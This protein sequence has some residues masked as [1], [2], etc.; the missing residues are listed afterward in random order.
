M[1]SKPPRLTQLINPFQVASGQYHFSK[2]IR[3]SKSKSKNSWQHMSLLLMMVKLK[4]RL[5]HTIQLWKCMLESWENKKSPFKIYLLFVMDCAAEWYKCNLPFMQI[6][7][8]TYH[9]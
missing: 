7:S 4:D 2:I 1:I 6:I 5:S 8:Q 3:R 9:Y